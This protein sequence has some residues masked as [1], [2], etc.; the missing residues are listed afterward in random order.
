[1]SAARRQ[2]DSDAVGKLATSGAAF[3]IPADLSPA[4]L[5]IQIRA[6]EKRVKRLETFVRELSSGNVNAKRRDT[7]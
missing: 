5:E 2:Y 7:T 1:M 3:L 6:L 4:R